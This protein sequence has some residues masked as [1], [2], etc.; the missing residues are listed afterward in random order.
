MFNLRSFLDNLDLSVKHKLPPDQRPE[1]VYLRKS[2]EPKC[3]VMYFPVKI[4]A[5]VEVHK[6]LLSLEN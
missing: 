3:K 2:I 6:P 1:K 5:G 4:Q